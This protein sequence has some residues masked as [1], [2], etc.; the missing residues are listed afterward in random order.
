MAVTLTSIV[1]NSGTVGTHVQ[2]NGMG[3][4]SGG[5][6]GIANFS[7]GVLANFSFLIEPVVSGS[8][9]GFARRLDAGADP[10]TPEGGALAS[11][12]S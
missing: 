2:L 3:F 11:A 12:G 4:T 5:F 9:S 8:V 1:P 7:P 6:N 10:R